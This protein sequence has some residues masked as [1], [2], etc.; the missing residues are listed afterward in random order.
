MSDEKKLTLR[1]KLSRTR[2][3]LRDAPDLL[4][5]VW[6]QLSVVMSRATDLEQASAEQ[7][8]RLRRIEAI[9]PDY[10]SALVSEICRDH[11]GLTKLNRELSIHPTIW[12]DPARLHVSPAASVF[13]CFFNTN[14]GEIFIS[15]HTFAGSRVSIL[16]GSHD[17]HLT[18][19]LRRDAELTEGCDIR[20]GK[21]V[22]LASGCTVLGPCTIGDNAVIAAG[23]VV[24]PGTEVPPGT[25][26]GGIPARRI[27]SLDLADPSDLFSPAVQ[28]ALARNGG[29]L[30]LSG[31][32]PKEP[33][34]LSVPGYWLTGEEGRILAASNRWQLLYYWANE[35]GGG[36]TVSGRDGS[37]E[38]DLP[39]EQ[40]AV[41]GRLP[42]R[43]TGLSEITIKKTSGDGKPMLALVQAENLKEDDSHE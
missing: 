1:E 41:P 3:F 10:L 43:E 14:S 32:S 25:I 4:E 23:A 21:G 34:F 33:G 7:D 42:F 28:E 2:A 24:V 17:Q 15:D 11:E 8:R 31:W 5:T 18:G 20:I 19:F 13:T 6:E 36:I 40:G 9:D 16:A 38:L 22:W 12:G 29:K 27:G 26:F 37:S 35:P 39:E 30:F